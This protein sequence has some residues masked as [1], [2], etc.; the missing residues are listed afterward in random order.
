MDVD[1]LWREYHAEIAGYLRRRMGDAAAEV[2]SDVWWRVVKHEKRHGELLR[3][4]RAWLYA[5]ARSA[6]IDYHR[7]NKD[8]GELC[9]EALALGSRTPAPES[10]AL[11]RERLREV[12]ACI[13]RLSEEQREVMQMYAVEGLSQAEIGR[14]TGRRANA[15][16]QIVRRARVRVRDES[17][18]DG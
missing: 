16:Q 9:W 8:R 14:R 13:E 2:E 5:V 7:L 4:P 6:M 17:R 3:N 15:V 10:V 12:Q 11:A 1:G 18:F